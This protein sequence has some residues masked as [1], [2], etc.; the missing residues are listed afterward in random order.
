MLIILRKK[1]KLHKIFTYPAPYV[2]SCAQ[3]SAKVEH[4]LECSTECIDDDLNTNKPCGNFKCTK[5]DSGYFYS[6]EMQSCSKC[7]SN[8]ESCSDSNACL[9]CNTGFVLNGTIFQPFNNTCVDNEH[10]DLD[11]SN[12]TDYGHIEIIK[13]EYN[14]TTSESNG[15]AL[16][17]INNGVTLINSTFTS[18]KSSEGGTVIICI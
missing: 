8:C 18:C 7:P 10:C 9:S 11:N 4:C 13:P 17:I 14:G 3:C 5:C 16:N 15:G 12:G 2:G 1:G 6:D